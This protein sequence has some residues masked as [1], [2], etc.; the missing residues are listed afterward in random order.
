[1]KILVITHAFPP[2]A[3]G[4]GSYYIFDLVKS[5]SNLGHDVSV[6]SAKSKKRKFGEVSREF[7]VDFIDGPPYYYHIWYNIK[8]K[9]YIKSYDIRKFDFV[10][11]HFPISFKLPIPTMMHVHY[12]RPMWKKY[13]YVVYPGNKIKSKLLSLFDGTVGDYTKKYVENRSLIFPDG[14]GYNSKHTKRY[15]EYYYPF[16]KDKKS[17]IIY[18]GVDE[19][20]FASTSNER[21]DYFFFV[22]GLSPG[23]GLY[24]IINAVKNRKLDYKIKIVGGGGLISEIEAEKLKGIN[25]IEYIGRVEQKKMPELYSK[26]I[27]TIHPTRYDAF[28]DVILESL[29]C[30]TPVIVSNENFCG[31]SE[32]VPDNTAKKIN[33][34]SSTELLNAM[35]E[36][37]ERK[38]EI[39]REECRKFALEHTWD[40]VAKEV[41]SLWRIL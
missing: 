41:L 23:K 25:N 36:M 33:P 29:A 12:C 27:A 8:L 6:I 21:N 11:S 22:G 37:Y 26:A 10:S 9:K 40:K 24:T 35:N 3:L 32:I 39:K 16:V 30:G 20:L 14:L 34:L 28:G 38:D 15:M 13:Y 31:A 2:Y 4:G 5:F 1:M 17:S 19:K 18:N 7:L